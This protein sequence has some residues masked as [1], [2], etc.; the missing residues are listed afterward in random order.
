M[1]ADMTSKTGIFFVAPAAVIMAALILTPPAYAQSTQ[2]PEPLE[3]AAAPP[4]EQVQQAPRPATPPPTGAQSPY[5]TS[6]IGFEA[7]THDT[8][9]AFAGPSYVKPFR[10]NVAWVAGANLNYLYYEYANGPGHTNVRSPGVNAMGGVRFG[11]GSYLQLL[12]GP[13]FKRRFVETVDESGNTLRSS[14][15]IKVGL[16]LGADAYINPTRHNN[17]FGMVRYG[18]EDR[19]TW[20]RLAYKEQISNLDWS[21]KYASFVGAE[22]I[23]QGNNDIRSTQVGAF[24][25]IAHAPSSV[26][27]TFRGGYKKSAY[28]FGPDKSGP[29]F[30]IGF[31]HRLR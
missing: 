3:S 10:P 29:W 1:G 23:G 17:I 24:Y 11:T 9:Y 6:N 22:V 21:R 25:E 30:A 8:G 16:N 4:P 2:S 19:Y 26:S 7:D 31:W 14:R 20:T 15:D 28:D 5:W 18:A 27:I 13:G 12:A